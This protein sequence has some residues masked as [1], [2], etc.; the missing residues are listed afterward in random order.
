MIEAAG[1]TVSHKDGSSCMAV[2][3]GP[4]QSFGL[5]SCPALK[6][7]AGIVSMY[8]RGGPVEFEP[9]GY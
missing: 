5:G 4:A 1:V 8:S 9:R 2:P 3:A 6:A 7:I